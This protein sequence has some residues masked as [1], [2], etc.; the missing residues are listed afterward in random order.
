MAGEPKIGPLTLAEA[1]HAAVLPEL[2]EETYRTALQAYVA[3]K[4]WQK[5]EAALRHLEPAQ[6]GSPDAVRQ[7]TQAMIRSGRDWKEQLQRL[8]SQQRTVGA[9]E[10]Q[11]LL[12]RFLWQITDGP[13][14]KSFF[15]LLWVAEAYFGLGAA[16]DPAEP[17]PPGEGQSKRPPQALAYYRAAADTYRKI[18]QQGEADKKFPPNR[19]PWSP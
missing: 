2:A 11:M 7:A 13:Q 16:L 14:G 8:R 10:L 17:V 1:R 6:P 5:A 9:A 19:M 15:S 4:Q 18:V 3:S 12:E